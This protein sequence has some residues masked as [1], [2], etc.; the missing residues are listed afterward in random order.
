MGYF[1]QVI[2]AGF[3]ICVGFLLFSFLRNL[4]HKIFIKHHKKYIEK[5]KKFAQKILSNSFL[6]F[7]LVISFTAP[8]IIDLDTIQVIPKKI[9]F[10]DLNI[11]KLE[12]VVVDTFSG[13]IQTILLPNEKIQMDLIIE[14]K[15]VELLFSII[16]APADITVE[17]TE[18]V[19]LLAKESI[20]QVITKPIIV[21][22]Q[23]LAF[24][25]PIDAIIRT[26]SIEISDDVGKIKEPIKKNISIKSTNLEKQT[27]SFSVP[28]NA[29]FSG[30][31]VLSVQELDEQQN[32][33]TGNT[34]KDITGRVS[35]EWQCN[36]CGQCTE[37]IKKALPG[38]VIVQQADL[39]NDNG[40]YKCIDLSNLLN[41]PPSITY[42][43]GGHWI[44]N[45]RSA[46]EL[47][48][49]TNVVIQNCKINNATYPL[50][51]VSTYNSEFNNIET[52][53]S[54]SGVRLIFSGYN[55][56][57]NIDSKNNN[58]GFFSDSSDNNMFDNIIASNNDN[59]GFQ[60][61]RSS[62]NN[63]IKNSRFENNG[64]GGIYFS[65]N[66]L[67]LPSNNLIYNNYFANHDENYSD[68]IPDSSFLLYNP[69]GGN[70]LINNMLALDKS[71]Y[72]IIE[73]R[74]NIEPDCNSGPNII[75]GECIA[76]NYWGNTLPESF[77]GDCI[78]T[79]QNGICD[80]LYNFSRSSSL[81]SKTY[82]SNGVDYYPLTD[83]VAG[84]DTCSSC[85]E[86]NDK[87]R[88]AN[89]GDII[90]LNSDLSDVGYLSIVGPGSCIYFGQDF[91]PVTFDCQDHTLSDYFKAF[92]FKYAN[93]N[94]IKNCRIKDSTWGFDITN[95]QDNTFLD[96]NA[97]S[98]ESLMGLL[99]SHNNM[100]Q[101]I[102]GINGDLG[103]FLH[104]SSN[105]V[106]DDIYFENINQYG[107]N[108]YANSDNN[109]IKN[110]RFIDA[111]GQLQGYVEG[112]V[113]FI[114]VSPGNYLPEN[115][116]V[117]NNYFD[118]DENFGFAGSPLTQY[119]NIFNT[120]LDC[121]S[122]PNIIGGDCIGGNYYV[123][124]DGGYSKTCVDDNNDGICDDSY[125]ISSDAFYYF[126]SCGEL[127]CGQDISFD[128]YP[129]TRLE[130]PIIDACENSV[131]DN[132][133]SD[134]DC[135]GSCDK[136]NINQT[137]STNLDCNSKLCINNK[138]GAQLLLNRK[139]PEQH[140]R[141]V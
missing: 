33:I 32:L 47:R 117:Y 76:G 136:C 39:I 135:G 59:Y 54:V 99:F 128:Y 66:A 44:K 10:T 30:K 46:I 119:T 65:G 129:L 113:R 3:I 112:A 93:G 124:R 13:D 60:M 50:E 83:N 85:G 28:K 106:F 73:N 115:N 87:I 105:N 55:K 108:L 7:F 116:L 78:D 63:I 101:R 36:T 53:D 123:T 15:P 109:I 23:E 81:G 17:I 89:P 16:R 122:G 1:T 21:Q 18:K 97:E 141:W 11:L 57:S 118:S 131:K 107:I 69:I 95:S 24:L 25:L 8:V 140:Y 90:K 26:A 35:K 94:T 104:S 43:C 138:C 58:I 114:S 27:F 67:A 5:E 134:V 34:L 98:V 62:S 121:N 96:I 71:Y 137:C 41:G 133:E 31:L 127:A 52:S 70:V 100:F 6:I 132:D 91:N 4:V 74:F 61:Y 80:Y 2:L 38:D 51:I 29:D 20:L 56:L 77:S 64:W 72:P 45:Y 120:E 92:R 12:N 48:I 49:I 75:G 88:S 139:L 126:L 102:S 14:E 9:F 125:N 103:F 37:M 68:P 130:S 111:S 79:D 82:P 40:S 86:C 22:D 110:S 42:D 84:D 19:S